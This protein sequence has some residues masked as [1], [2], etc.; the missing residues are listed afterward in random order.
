[1]DHEFKTLLA[2][3]S[4][5][6][7]ELAE[8]IDRYLEKNLP[9]KA[10]LEILKEKFPQVLKKLVRFETADNRVVVKPWSYLGGGIQQDHGDYRKGWRRIHLSW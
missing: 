6:L 1:M 4:R 8:V 9:A 3:V 5:T 7:K 2:E 10:R